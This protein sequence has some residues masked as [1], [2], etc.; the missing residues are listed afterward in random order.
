MIK[1]LFSLNL[2]QFII[3]TIIIVES[4]LTNTFD[5]LYL[6]DSQNGPYAE[7]NDDETYTKLLKLTIS[8]NKLLVLMANKK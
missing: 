2:I 4:K 6:K 3:I 5:Q 7:I 8:D 1:Y